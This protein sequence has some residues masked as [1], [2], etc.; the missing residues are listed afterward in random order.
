MRLL[1]DEH[2]SPT[3]VARLGELGTYAQSVPHVGLAGKADYEVWK[4]A[5]DHGFA[6]VTTNARDY[7]E[8]LNVDVH[9]GLIVLRESGLT[10]EEQWL[11]LKPVVEQANR[12]N[13]EDFFLN[14]LI[15]IAGV[16][17]FHARTIARE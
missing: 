7:I 12:A 4:Y 17:K 11:R 5:L 16:E 8:L 6:V 14:K 3:L 2:I 1:L 9:P 13:D 10:R 15:E